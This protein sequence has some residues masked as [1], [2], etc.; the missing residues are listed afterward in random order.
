MHPN[1]VT[2]N[3]KFRPAPT[4]R[5]NDPTLPRGTDLWIKRED[6][7]HP[8]ISGNKW[9]KL[10]Y[11]LDHALTLGYRNVISMGGAYSNHLH[12]LAYAGRE[13][14]IDTTGIIRGERPARTNA[15]I[16]DLRNWGMSL[17]FVSRSAFRKLREYKQWD[18]DPGQYYQGYWIPEGGSSPLA[19]AGLTEMVNDIPIDYQTI[20]L[21]CGTGVTLAGTVHALAND[22]CALG[23]AVLKGAEFLEKD[24][25]NFLRTANASVSHPPE[26]LH[27]FHFGGF[28]KRNQKLIGF[29]TDFERRNNIPLDPVYTGKLMYGVYQ[30]INNQ[31]LKNQ[32]IIAIHTGGLQANRDD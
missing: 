7:L 32:R 5:I 17:H 9:R 20:A 14:G 2:L 11:I 12:A 16:K 25:K 24:V 31:K 29:M 30:L 15:T 21:A 26:I 23:F 10:K 22:Q 6:L 3:S 1:I 27:D 28:A 4:L 13:L 8:I 19:L 18:S